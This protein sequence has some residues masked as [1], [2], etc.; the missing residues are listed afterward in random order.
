MDG[1]DPLSYTHVLHPAFLFLPPFLPAE[2][3]GGFEREFDG[4]ANSKRILD[5]EEGVGKM[6]LPDA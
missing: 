2:N 5:C 3:L 4:K 6:G 1:P